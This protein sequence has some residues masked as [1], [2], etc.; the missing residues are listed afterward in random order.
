MLPMAID[1]AIGIT[2]QRSSGSFCKPCYQPLQ[3]AQA[4]NSPFMASANELQQGSPQKSMACMKLTT[5]VGG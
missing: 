4:S 3:L 1:F 2:I 5:G